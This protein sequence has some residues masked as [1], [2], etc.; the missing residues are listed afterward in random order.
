MTRLDELR[1]N[2]TAAM[3][4]FAAEALNHLPRRDEPRRPRYVGLCPMPAAMRF[5]VER[6]DSK[7]SRFGMEYRGE[8]RPFGGLNVAH[9]IAEWIVGTLNDAKR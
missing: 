5:Y 3:A 1:D 2:V 9:D 7:W 4:E 8:R 6:V